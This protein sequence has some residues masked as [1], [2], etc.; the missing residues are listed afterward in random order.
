[1]KVK[2][3]LLLSGA[4][5]AVGLPQVALAQTQTET[6][7]Q[8]AAGSNVA[9][10]PSAK[11]GNADIGDIIVTAQ[12]RAERAQDV[13][14]VITA[15]SAKQLDKLNVTQPQDLYGHVPSLTVGSQGQ[16]SRDVQS[17]TIRGQ[18]TGFLASP[19]VQLYM[20]EVPLPSSISLN[21]Q[22]APG[23]FFDLENVQVLEGPQGTLFG[24]N[25]TGGAVLFQAH[26]PEDHFSGYINAE[27]GNYDMRA[28]EG[29]LNLPIIPDTLSI[30]IG[31]RYEDRRGFTHDL[32]WNKWRDD[33][34]Y[35][36]GRI[37][38]NFTPTENF[39]NYLLAYGS[40]SHTNG[41]GFINQGFNIP[42]LIAGGKC[43]DGTPT[44]SLA[45]CDVYR[46]Q[47]DIAAQ[48]GPR[49]NRD[50]LDGY[51][52]IGSWG[53]IDNAAL[54]LNENLTLRNIVSYQKLYDNYATDQDGTPL[55]TYELSQNGNVPDFPISGFA[56]LFGLPATPGNV[57]TNRTEKTGPRDYIQQFTEELQLQGSAFDKNLTFAAGGFYF[58]ATPAGPWGSASAQF[59]G[60]AETGTAACV[61]SL[62]S[63]SERSKSKAL[64]AQ[65][66]LNFGAVTPSLEGLRLT[67]G[68]RYTWDDISGSS[69]SWIP[70]AGNFCIFGDKAGEFSPS[71][72][73]PA[74]GCSFSAKLKTSA[75]TW[76]VGLDYKPITGLLVY[77]KISRG[78]KAGGF[79]TFAVRANTQTFDPERLTSYEAGFKSDWHLGGM[80]GMFNA[81]GYYSDYTNVQRAGGDFA[82]INGYGAGGA[83]IYSAT[84]TIKGFELEGNIRPV[85]GLEFGGNLSY[86][87]AKYKKYEIPSL[88]G[89][90]CNNAP[91]GATADLSC[92]A[93]EYVTPWIFNVYTSIDVPVPASVGKVNLYVNYSH[94]SSQYTVP[95]PFEPEAY[96]EPHGLLNATLTWSDAFTK[97]LQA[98][99]FAT[100]LTNKLYR[101]GV[102]GSWYSYGLLSTLYGEPRMFG[103]KLR[104]SFGE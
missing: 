97:G 19:G 52:I 2:L 26:K 46:K 15:F 34:H 84:A 59:C 39:S 99:L 30:R 79:N 12:R 60:A 23:M 72:V 44:P 5:I 45:S 75:P 37:G 53:V 64:Y 57:Y 77:G 58:N 29:V 36:T 100:N 18:S 88:G 47:A 3:Y 70:A 1:M 49:A 40:Y 101:V 50:S 71:G 24:R 94:V 7:T 38:I 95:T 17:F 25:T 8:A 61:E 103:L 104:Y 31:G 9:S 51:S 90:S 82:I 62:S 54:K 80:P 16:G 76:T 22:G 56:D 28:V 68:Y 20:N 63:S 48:I 74:V 91:F 92:A 86:T 11:T 65:G 93:F 102:S 6:S 87:D 13:P 43:T 27:V 42:A 4:S 98:T 35:Y 10:T 21:L 83:A 96:L 66:T 67:A 85:P 73:D 55:Q 81:T 14:I 33:L 32:V 89:V 41:P 69:A 78:Y